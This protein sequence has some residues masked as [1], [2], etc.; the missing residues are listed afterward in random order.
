MGDERAE[1]RADGLRDYGTVLW[2]GR[3]E[4]VTPF[5][6]LDV[7]WVPFSFVWLASVTFGTVSASRGGAPW[8]AFI[9]MGLMWLFGLY[10]VVGRFFVKAAVSKRTTYIVTERFAIIERGGSFEARAVDPTSIRIRRRVAGR[11]EA[12]FD[13]TLQGRRS[14]VQMTYEMYRNTGMDFMATVAT[15]GWAPLR[16]Y[17]VR[18]RAGLFEALRAAGVDLV[19]R[20]APGG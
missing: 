1:E 12:D 14:L 10:L 2:R 6:A 17:D 13:A 9:G 18:D 19:D 5:V 11:I 16:F 7:F 3:P 15:G 8:P 20:G 4:P